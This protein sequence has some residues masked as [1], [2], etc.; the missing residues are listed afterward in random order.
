MSQAALRSN[1]ALQALPKRPEERRGRTLSPRARGANQTTPHG[2]LQRLL[3][4]SGTATTAIEPGED[5]ISKENPE[6]VAE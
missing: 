1:E 2:P 3:D 4:G 5:Q 6:R